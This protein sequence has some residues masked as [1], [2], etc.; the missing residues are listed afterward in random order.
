M[1]RRD[2]LEGL[3]NRTLIKLGI[4][5]GG[6]II[7]LFVGALLLGHLRCEPSRDE[8]DQQILLL[9]E[10]IEELE[11]MQRADGGADAVYACDSPTCTEECAADCPGWMEGYITQSTACG[12]T[13]PAFVDCLS[14]ATCD[15][16]DAFFDGYP[17]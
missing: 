13:F 14:S 9:L 11:E 4:I 8:L 7:L 5:V 6:V 12:A 10:K 2:L 17:D 16:W 3:S 15:E 1:Q